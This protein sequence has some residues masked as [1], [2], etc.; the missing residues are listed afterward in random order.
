MERFALPVLLVAA[1]AAFS[2]PS[3]FVEATPDFQP[4]P[5]QLE[6]SKD[7]PGFSLSEGIRI[8][9]A[10][11]HSPMGRAL[12]RELQAAEVPVLPEEV[13]GAM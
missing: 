12:I 2:A 3:A 6:L 7:K 9:A 1:S 8:D 5:K 10:T 13:E 11:R 4:A